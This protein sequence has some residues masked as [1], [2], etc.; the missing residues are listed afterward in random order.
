MRFIDASVFLYAY[1][2]PTRKIPADIEILKRNA[3][4]IV[5][6]INSGE[7]QV[8]T[9]LIHISEIANILGA[10]TSLETTADIVSGL[11]DLSN[12]Q[13]MEP[14]RALYESSVE[15]S[16][17]YSIGVNDGLAFLLM[18]RE[19]ISEIYIFDK[20]FD[21]IKELKRIME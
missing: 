14:S 2:K 19:H 5:K 6:K 18:K 11:L 15:S 10:R 17:S 9:S 20:D 8:T 4:D 1:L 7:E 21:K 12:L 3:R 13:I 16:R